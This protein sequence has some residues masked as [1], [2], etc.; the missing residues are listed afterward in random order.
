MKRV[1][2]DLNDMQEVVAFVSAVFQ[3]IECAHVRQSYDVCQH[4]FTILHCVFNTL[5]S[6]ELL[7]GQIGLA[8]YALDHSERY[9]GTCAYLLER[10]RDSIV[11]YDEK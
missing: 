5:N 11:Q 9:P 4:Y 10:L 8:E 3:V 1:K 7:D 2:F 6:V